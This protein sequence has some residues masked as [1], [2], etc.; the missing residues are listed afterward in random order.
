M[1]LLQIHN[2][3][4]IAAIFTNNALGS[5]VNDGSLQGASF[6]AGSLWNVE[7]WL[8]Y[9]LQK[10]FVRPLPACLLGCSKQTSTDAI[11]T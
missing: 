4:I 7:K 10:S 11:L 3:F 9:L 2:D 8:D 6:L 1:H 5:L